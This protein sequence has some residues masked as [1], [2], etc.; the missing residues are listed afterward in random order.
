MQQC[1]LLYLKVAKSS[2]SAQDSYTTYCVCWGGTFLYIK[3]PCRFYLQRPVYETCLSFNYPQP[4]FFLIGLPSSYFT[5]DSLT[6]LQFHMFVCI[7]MM[8]IVHNFL[9]FYLMAD[10]NQAQP[11]F[12]TGSA[13]QEWPCPEKLRETYCSCRRNSHF[14]NCCRDD[15]AMYQPG[16][17]GF[18]LEKCMYNTNCTFLWSFL[19]FSVSLVTCVKFVLSGS[20]LENI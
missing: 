16:K 9:P 19:V 14:K 6:L 4:N 13:Q 1:K 2:K 8:E 15:I 20:F 10:G 3:F 5:S 17:Q 11:K 7:I 18:I 12:N